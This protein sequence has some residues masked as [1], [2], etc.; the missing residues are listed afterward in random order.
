MKSFLIRLFLLWEFFSLWPY[1]FSMDIFNS[2]NEQRRGWNQLYVLEEQTITN[3][4]KVGQIKTD[5][6][7]NDGTV[8]YILTGEGANTIFSIDENTGV[9][10]V[11]KKLDREEKSSYTLRAQAINILTGVPLE[12]ESEFKINIQDINDNEPKFVNEPYI[13]NVPEMSPEGTSVIQV[14]A[15]DMDDPSYGNSAILIY[16]ILQGQPHFSIEPK[17]GIIR[18]ASQIDRE[19]KDKYHVVIQA[20]DMVGQMGGLSATTTAT[21]SLTD[22]NDNAPKFQQKIYEMSILESSLVGEMVGTIIADDSD[23]GMNAEIVY[24]IEEKGDFSSFDII[25]DY[26]TQEGIITLKKVVDYETKKRYIIQV[27]ATNKHIDERLTR[28]GLFEDT[29]TI[30]INVED[31]DEPPVFLLNEYYLEVFENTPRGS[32]IGSVSARDPD[33]TNSPIRYYIS[34]KYDFRWFVIDAERGSII[35][36]KPLDREVASWHNITITATETKNPTH[37]AEVPVHIRVID[38]ND[39]APQFSKEY[40]TY[41]CEN[42]KRGQL[43]ETISAVDEDDPATS[44]IFS[45]TLSPESKSDANFTVRDNRDNTAGVF[46]LRDGFSYEDNTLYYLTVLISDNGTPSLSSTNTLTIRVC[47][48]GVDGNTES[49][50]Q[51]GFLGQNTG[52]LIS[53]SL[54]VPLILVFVI[55]IIILKQRKKHNV[56]S[57]K[58]DFRE[59]FVSYDDEGG[60]EEDTKAFDIVGL[61][62]PP[63]IMRQNNPKRRMRTDI[64]SFYRM[65]LGLGPDI[66][67]FRD[68][69]IEKIEEANEDLNDLSFDFVQRYAFEGTGSMTG[70][71]SSIESSYSDVD[72]NSE[73]IGNWGPRF[74]KIADMYRETKALKNKQ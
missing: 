38:V 12:P 68:F 57:E 47:D 74:Q 52:A 73:N 32:Y 29:T 58:G 54:G 7:K 69:L 62:N 71:L 59:N 2:F 63:T 45:F 25:T 30:K 35:T 43:I 36:V 51:H 28:H 8:N 72:P 53:V 49:C 33:D 67:I 70:S 20:K 17:S 15:T 60:G 66:G 41:V 18:V 64:Q 9:I 10:Y 46:T 44:N 31:V 40:D 11:L 65:S 21:I 39:H 14:T 48:C 55:T 50:K 34:K 24:V 37:V 61:R 3:P 42:A 16:S 4:L 5:M 26:A 27:K 6:D 1:V 13:A 22:V 19:A 56:L 23:I